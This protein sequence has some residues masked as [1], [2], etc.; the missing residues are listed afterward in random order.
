MRVFLVLCLL[1][2][3][4]SIDFIKTGLCLFK[5]EN[6]RAIVKDVVA[7][8]KER[9]FANLINIA[10]NKFKELKS[11]VTDCIEDEVVLKCVSYEQC[12]VNCDTYFRSSKL[13]K[14]ACVQTSCK[15]K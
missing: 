9:D 3:I 5:N 2:S 6:L 10:L 4:T 12:L 7:S 11:I 1:A 14:A 8:I 13:C 15:K